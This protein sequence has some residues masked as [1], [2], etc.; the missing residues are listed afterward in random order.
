MRPSPRRAPN[1]DYQDPRAYLAEGFFRPDGHPRPALHTTLAMAMGRELLLRAVPLETLGAVVQ[2]FTGLAASGQPV[3]QARAWLLERTRDPG[4]QRHRCLVR[5]LQAG[6]GALRQQEDLPALARHLTRVH[7]L[8]AFERALG[9]AID[10]EQA[11]A[12]LRGTRARQVRASRPRQDDPG[13]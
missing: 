12:A 7:Q 10:L 11:A 1:P 9:R 3:E 13:F 6:A 4:L 2:A 8:A 5:L